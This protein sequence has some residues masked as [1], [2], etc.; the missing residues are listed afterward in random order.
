MILASVGPGP[1]PESTLV[2]YLDR[3]MGF[4][5]IQHDIFL[6]CST[7]RCRPQ[8]A[9]RERK[10]HRCGADYRIAHRLASLPFCASVAPQAFNGNLPAAADRPGP[11][12]T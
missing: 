1:S 7:Q 3:W 12:S 8:Y 5:Q 6:L 9:P 11:F 4:N 10:R 2:A